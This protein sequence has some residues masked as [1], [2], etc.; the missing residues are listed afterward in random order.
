MVEVSTAPQENL[1]VKLKLK[2]KREKI[3][4]AVKKGDYA[5]LMVEA[6]NIAASYGLEAKQ[7]LEYYDGSS[8]VLVENDQDL[9]FAFEFASIHAKSKTRSVRPARTPEEC[10]QITFSIRLPFVEPT[11]EEIEVKA[12]RKRD[13]ANR[14]PLTPEE[15]EAKAQK[16]RE[17]ASRRNRNS[18]DEKAANDV[19]GP[20]PDE[21][22]TV[23]YD[24]ARKQVTTEAPRWMP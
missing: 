2:N 1:L 10:N 17:K 24:C 15:I 4:K 11:A 23:V 9:A 19:E 21:E 5:S 16:K 12:Q 13:K 22:S 14:P 18:R 20:I 3:H 8:W 6:T 7:G